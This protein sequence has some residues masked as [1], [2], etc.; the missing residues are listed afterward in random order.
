MCSVR[1]WE[2]EEKEEKGEDMGENDPL[3]S[4]PNLV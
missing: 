3:K 2:E 1:T 4:A